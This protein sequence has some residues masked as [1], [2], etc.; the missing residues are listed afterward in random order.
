MYTMSE[1]ILK[2]YNIPF[3]ILIPLIKE[4][5]RKA[6]VVSPKDA[7][8]GPAARGDMKIINKHIDLLDSEPEKNIYKMISKEIMN[9]RK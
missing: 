8:T 6:S 3:S 5:V 1:N 9:S 7:Q 2:K 4:T